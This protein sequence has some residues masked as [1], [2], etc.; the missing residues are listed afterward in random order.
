MHALM[1]PTVLVLTRMICAE[2]DSVKLFSMLKFS[3]NLSKLFTFT[4]AQPVY[5]GPIISTI[6]SKGKLVLQ[7]HFH[8]LH[9]I[10]EILSRH[11]VK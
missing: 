8:E 6:F 5:L 11:G 10:Y 3:G 2:Y 7:I 1:S 4:Y 9:I